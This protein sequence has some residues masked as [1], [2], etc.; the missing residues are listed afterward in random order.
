M[1]FGPSDARIR[2]ADEL[3]EVWPQFAAFCEKW[4]M[5][6]Y[7]YKKAVMVAWSEDFCDV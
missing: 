5:E 2:M 1:V 7:P 3:S 6:P 4:T